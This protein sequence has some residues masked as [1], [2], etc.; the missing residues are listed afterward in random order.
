MAFFSTSAVMILTFVVFA[1]ATTPSTAHKVTDTEIK[2]LCSKSSHPARCYE[3]LKS[4]HR[5]ANVDAKGLVEVSV[6]LAAKKANKIHSQLNSF[7]KATHDSRFRNLYDSCSKNY[8]DA[9]RNLEVAKSNLHSGAYKNIHAQVK[10][11][12]EEIK[13]CEK[14]LGEASSDHAHIKK[15]SQDLEF[16]LNVVKITSDNL[17]KN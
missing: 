1:L 12:S 16:R 14:V 5:T 2:H 17:K 6:D 10:D 9:I 7:S 4:D 15:K 13:T 11:A 3:L 8:N